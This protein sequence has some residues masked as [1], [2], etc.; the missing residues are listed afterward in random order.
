MDGQ[1]AAA[2]R[3]A[4]AE[5]RAARRLAQAHVAALRSAARGVV[6]MPAE[7]VPHAERVRR[8]VPE[9]GAPRVPPAARTLQDHRARAAL[10]LLLLLRASVPPRLS[11]L[12]RK[13]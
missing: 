2:Q 3:V 7:R 11:P 9:P 13:R 8:A 5:P 12:R 6:P 10:L 1:S 4:F